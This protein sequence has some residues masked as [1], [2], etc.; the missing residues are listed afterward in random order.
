MVKPVSEVLIVSVSDLIIETSERQLKAEYSDD[1]ILSFGTTKSK[2]QNKS[3]DKRYNT[4]QTNNPIPYEYHQDR[5]SSSYN[6]G[7]Y[8]QG[9]YH[10]GPYHSGPYQ[11]DY[12]T[13]PFVPHPERFQFVPHRMPTPPVL[14]HQPTFEHTSRS[15]KPDLRA[16]ASIIKKQ[17]QNIND[18]NSSYENKPVQDKDKSGDKPTP[19]SSRSTSDPV[20]NI[21]FNEEE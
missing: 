17:L 7:P 5:F 14:F 11:T 3:T 19:G 1:G 21:K 9:P 20:D 10:P 2:R 4:H 18:K 12:R 8:H 16:E 13:H 15:D 6:P